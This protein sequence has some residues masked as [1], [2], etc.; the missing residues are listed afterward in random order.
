[1][2]NK[3]FVYVEIL[4]NLKLI[5]HEC[6]HYN[7]IKNPYSRELPISKSLLLQGRRDR[8]DKGLCIGNERHV[9][10]WLSVGI[11]FFI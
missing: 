2:L 5:I 1:M 8:K 9:C 4:Y 11:K 10:N 3:K 7:K 6:T